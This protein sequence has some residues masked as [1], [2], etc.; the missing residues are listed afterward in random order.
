MKLSCILID[1]EPLA[2]NLL[3][4]YINSIPFLELKAKCNNAIV[5][6]EIIENENI[7]LI[8]TDIQMPN[9]SGLEFSKMILN[10]NIKVIFTTAFEEF[11]LEGYKVNAIDYLVKPISYTEFFS[12]ANKAKQLLF[13]SAPS[14]T[15]MD[16][17]IFIKS[18]YKLIKINLKDIIYVE[19]LKD[20][21][22]FYTVNS[23]KP[24]LTLKS[25]KS[26]EE[27]LSNKYFM[28]VHRSFLVNLKMITTVER[29]RIVF[30]EKYIPISEKYKE[31]FQKFI[32]GDFLK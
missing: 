13:N 17:Y 16:D 19:G 25:M 31:N 29:N 14:K 15:S 32:E 28:R 21:L 10:K 2:L 11:A 22:K 6:F 30:G 9:L 26:L 27:E 20:Y 24:Y 3:E 23:E 1:D 4:G 8:F 5:A 12:A 18:D 7:D